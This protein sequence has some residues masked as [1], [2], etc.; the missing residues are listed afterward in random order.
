[1]IKEAIAALID[2]NDL[3]QI[4]MQSVFEEIMRGL[5]SPVRMSAFLT[6]LRMKGET[7]EEIS[8][9]ALAMRALVKRINIE[10]DVILDT[11]GTGGDIKH[12]FNISTISA[13]VAAGCG[14]VVAKHGNRAV[15]SACGSADLLEALGVNINIDEEK[16]EACVRT[17]GIGF[18]FAPNLHPAMKYAADVRKE[19]GLRTIFNLLGPLTNPALA[20][21]QLLG[22]YDPKLLT[23][24][25]EVLAYLGVKHGLVVHGLDGL[26]E[27]TTTTFTK[28]CELKNKKLRSYQINP[29]DFG[30]KRSRLKD[31]EGG[32]AQD[33]ARLTLEI[34]QSKK[35]PKRD[36]V[37]LNSACAIYTADKAGSI[38]EGLA[39]ARQ[40]I[41]SG[42]ALR[43]LEELK[44]VTNNR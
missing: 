6:A 32:N 5:V 38:K 36:I 31:L 43:K 28:I 29:S 15:S 44:R 13:L 24:L 12:T 4:Q 40:S 10:E 25:A 33:N 19:L 17:V 37:L 34:L 8:G 3:T 1:M 23:V 35:G 42:S 18:L 27:I 7:A 39:L 30:I 20:T 9:A 11:C 41:D 2:K 26:D 22:V 16:V 21:H 14:L